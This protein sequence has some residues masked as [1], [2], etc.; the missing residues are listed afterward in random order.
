MAFRIGYG[1]ASFSCDTCT[2]TQ[3]LDGW[4]MSLGG[5]GTLNP[6]F[7]LGGDLRFWANGL[8]GGGKP[9]PLIGVVTLM[10]SYYPRTHGGPF[11]Q[12][13]GGLSGYDACKG[14]GDPLEPCG[15]DAS[16]SGG[17]G[18]G[19]NVGAGWEIPIWGRKLRPLLV[20]HHGVVRKLHGP[21][22]STVVTGWHQNLLTLELT[23]LGE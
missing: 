17:W 20:Y 21:D 22:G 18:R 3:R 10:L 16:Y 6:H 12:G 2:A 9:L 11:L 14:R 15:N 1:R 19:V 23:L 8:G 7:R 5:G 4:T 13:G